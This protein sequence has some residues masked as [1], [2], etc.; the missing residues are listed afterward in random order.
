MERDNDFLK[1]RAGHL[2][3]TRKD[4]TMKGVL[5]LYEIIALYR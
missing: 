2:L 4:D 5:Q 3:C 1:G